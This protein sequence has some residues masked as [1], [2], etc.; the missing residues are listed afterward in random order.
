MRRTLQHAESLNWS[1]FG[2]Q[3]TKLQQFFKS[4]KP[5]IKKICLLLTTSYYSNFLSRIFNSYL[6]KAFPH[7]NKYGDFLAISSDISSAMTL[8]TTARTTTRATFINT[9]TSNAQIY[10]TITISTTTI[11]PSG[12]VTYRALGFCAGITILIVVNSSSC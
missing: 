2:N 10:N 5:P 12:S 1:L 7:I 11:A 4:T 3:R 6:Q 8:I 9:I